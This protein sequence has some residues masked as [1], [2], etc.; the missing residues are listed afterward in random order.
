MYVNRIM[1]SI[2]I[3]EKD[4]VGLLMDISYILGKEGI[5]IESIA[6]TAVGD[7]AVITMVVKDYEK[8]FEVLKK[9]GFNVLE[10]HMIIIKLED[11]PGELSKVAKTLA[12]AGINIKNLYVVS[13]DGKHTLV[14]LSVEKDKMKK[15]RELLKNYLV[16]ENS[17]LV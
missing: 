12:D 2:T 3:V 11:K 4:K 5:N 9:N 17:D 1:R 14:A 13:R 16:E 6:A 8:A 10:E 15:A 7:R